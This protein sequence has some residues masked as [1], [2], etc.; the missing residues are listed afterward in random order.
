MKEKV[1]RNKWKAFVLIIFSVYSACLIVFYDS[2]HF[3][4]SI[5]GSIAYNY[6]QIDHLVIRLIFIPICTVVC[7]LLTLCICRVYED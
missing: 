6:V 1:V 3:G 4:G 5:F 2:F 7:G